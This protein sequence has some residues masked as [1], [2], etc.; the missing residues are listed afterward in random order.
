[1][2]SSTNCTGSLAHAIARGKI[3]Y[4]VYERAGRINSLLNHARVCQDCFLL[5]LVQQIL[6]LYLI[7]VVLLGTRSVIQELVQYVF[8]CLVCLFISL[9]PSS[10]FWLLTILAHKPYNILPC[11]YVLIIH[12]LN[13]C[14]W[15]I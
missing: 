15:I 9:L 7:P 1:M 4:F 8:L 3:F 11:F 2:T 12:K 5:M 6:P 13:R 14:V 10:I